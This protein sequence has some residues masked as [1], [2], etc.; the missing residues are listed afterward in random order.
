[1][2]VNGP[3]WSRPLH[4]GLGCLR[5]PIPSLAVRPAHWLLFTAYPSQV[6]RLW[7]LGLFKPIII[8][9][10]QLY[11][12]PRG[13]TSSKKKFLE[14][15]LAQHTLFLPPQKEL[16]QHTQLNPANTVLAS[17]SFTNFP[18]PQFFHLCPRCQDGDQ[19]TL[20]SSYDQPQLHNFPHPTLLE[21]TESSC[22]SR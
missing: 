16:L 2:P 14:G 5:D 4:G 13:E 8:H 17:K 3:T 15:A 12:F 22:S 11:G 9:S 1:M 10:A 20:C 19:I 21:C 18:C 7:A 6:F